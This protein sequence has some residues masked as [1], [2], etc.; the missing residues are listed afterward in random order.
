MGRSATGAKR[1]ESK[2]SSVI[3]SG[4][5]RQIP[6]PRERAR[7]RRELDAVRNSAYCLT[8]NKR[9]CELS[10][11]VVGE[12]VVA[13]NGTA[14]ISVRWTGKDPV[15]HDAGIGL[16]RETP[17]GRQSD[18]QTESGRGSQRATISFNRTTQLLVLIVTE[19]EMRVQRAQPENRA[20]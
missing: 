20:S 16:D 14:Y 4:Q 15:H 10:L 3:S 7:V 6:R 5:Q 17:R 12:S 18:S 2:V 1:C 13:A 9:S 8:H 11:C 19:E